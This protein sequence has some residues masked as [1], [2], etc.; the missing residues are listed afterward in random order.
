[1]LVGVNLVI[2]VDPMALD[3]RIYHAL[4]ILPA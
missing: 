3:H 4:V 2:V 1:M